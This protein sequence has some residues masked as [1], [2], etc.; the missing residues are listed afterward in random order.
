MGGYCAILGIW[1]QIPWSDLGVDV[2]RRIHTKIIGINVL[3]LAAII[4]NYLA[5]AFAFYTQVIGLN[6]NY[7]FHVGCNNTIADA[8]FKGSK[9]Q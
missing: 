2:V 5:V 9:T 7:R 8:W 3:E 1:W 6:H 4:M